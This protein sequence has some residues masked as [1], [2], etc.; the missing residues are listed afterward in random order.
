MTM[1]DA[2]ETKAMADQDC[3]GSN[4]A[5]SMAVPK[6]RLVSF[7]SVCPMRSRFAALRADGPVAVAAD[8][9][10]GPTNAQ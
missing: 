4:S 6:F 10:G 5:V 7:L 2:N 1:H 8:T 9:K 3:G